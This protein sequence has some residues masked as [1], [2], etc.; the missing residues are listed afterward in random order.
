MPRQRHHF[1]KGSVIKKQYKILRKVGSGGFGVVYQARDMRL[2]RD[3]AIKALTHHDDVSKERFGQE[4]R[5][6]ARI[7]NQYVVSVYNRGKHKDVPYF[8]MEFVRYSL[9]DLLECDYRD[10]PVESELAIRILRQ[11]LEGLTKVHDQ[12]WTHRDIKPENILLTDDDEVRLADFGLIKDTDV[13]LTEKGAIMGTLKWMAPEQ[14]KGLEVSERTDIYAFGLVAFRTISGE[15]YPC[16]S[17]E[18]SLFTDRRTARLVSSCLEERPSDRPEDAQAVLQD[19]NEIQGKIR[20]RPRIRGDALVGNVRSRVER[21]Y[22]LPEGSVKLVYPSSTR[23]VRA[24][25]KV[26][27][28]REKWEA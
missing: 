27:R 24:N 7:K 10:S 23:A 4:A 12:G 21:E 18:L 13:S 8:V 2:R 28:V 5:K 16:S 22:G 1:Q 26:S 25:V 3:V 14:R 19:W 6:L 15:H 9:A 11:T 20:Q 17:S